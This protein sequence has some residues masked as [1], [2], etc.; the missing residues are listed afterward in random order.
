MLVL[1]P[2][3]VTCAL[4]L[5]AGSLVMGS[6]IMRGDPLAALVMVAFNAC[7]IVF[8]SSI[9]SDSATF[10]I[11]LTRLTHFLIAGAFAVGMM[12]LLWPRDAKP[13]TV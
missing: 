3:I 8:S 10:S 13:T 2:S 6:R 11:W 5:L 7:L 12:A 9:G 4:V 1:N